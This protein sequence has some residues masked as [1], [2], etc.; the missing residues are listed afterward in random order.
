MKWLQYTMC[1]VKID[2]CLPSFMYD[3]FVVVFLLLVFFFGKCMCIDVCS[4]GMWQV[5]VCGHRI[6]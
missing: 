3:S 2:E 4:F 5:D 6:S 1:M